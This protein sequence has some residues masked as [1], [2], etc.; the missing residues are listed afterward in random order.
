MKKIMVILFAA[1]LLFSCADGEKTES[2]VSSEELSSVAS[3][4]EVEESSDSDIT[5]SLASSEDSEPVSVTA[6]KFTLGKLEMPLFQEFTSQ[7]VD[8][9]DLY[10]YS[11]N[12]VIV[13]SMELLEKLDE[14]KLG[15]LTNAE[16]Y[17]LMH[18]QTNGINAPVY[19]D[20]SGD[21]AWFEYVQ[22]V[23]G[24]PFRYMSFC[25]MG[26]DAFYTCQFVC[27]EADADAL[28]PTIQTTVASF[29][30]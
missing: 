2:G 3:S 30:F 6:D 24:T 15:K 1:L 9:F 5:E 23:E 28:R 29:C 14:N 7:A 4:A 25:I 16:E 17:A 10:L 22:E 11:D 20:E 18:V 19:Y 8:D 26:D 27:A 21:Y 12:V 13:A